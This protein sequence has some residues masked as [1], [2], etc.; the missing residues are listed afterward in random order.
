M[1]S[2]SEPSVGL[3]VIVTD[4]GHVVHG[5]G[6]VVREVTRF[7]LPP[8]IAEFIQRMRAFPMCQVSLAVDITEPGK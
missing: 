7:P 4:I 2:R 8:E 5:G 3:A 1:T 6:D